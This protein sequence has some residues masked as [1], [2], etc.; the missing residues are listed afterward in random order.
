MTQKNTKALSEWLKRGKIELSQYLTTTANF[1]F[2]LILERII[3]DNLDC[4]A[5]TKLVQSHCERQ[6]HISA[7]KGPFSLT[8]YKTLGADLLETQRTILNP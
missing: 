2:I 3:K 1:R 7:L 5:T 4:K 6:K 8:T